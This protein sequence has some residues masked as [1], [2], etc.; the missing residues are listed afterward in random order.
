VI[1]VDIGFD[2]ND[3]VPICLRKHRDNY[4]RPIA[5]VYKA[6]KN[7]NLKAMEGGWSPYFM[8]YGR[9]ASTMPSS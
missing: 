5:Y 3:P 6:G 1:S 2:T 9:P 8:K 7:Y 4:G